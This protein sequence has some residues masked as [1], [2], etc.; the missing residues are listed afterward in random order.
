MFESKGMILFAVIVLLVCVGCFVEYEINKVLKSTS[1][2]AKSIQ[3]LDSHLSPEL[4]ELDEK[5]INVDLMLRR[6]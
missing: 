1:E 4:E 2:I 6:R 5:G 3:V